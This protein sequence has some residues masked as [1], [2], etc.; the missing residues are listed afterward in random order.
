M[1]QRGNSTLGM[2]LMLLLLGGVTLHATRTQLEKDV[3][4]VADEQ[5]HHKDF[6]Q[7]QAALEWGLAQS[8]PPVSGWQCQTLPSHRWQSCLLTMEEGNALLSG[9]E[10]GR[11]LR[12]WQWVSRQSDSLQP[13]AQGR[14]D[15]CPLP[16][17]EQCQP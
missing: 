15:Y 13:Q 4:L 8:W 2:V 6:W 9:Q 12:L 5:Q 10:E 1:N 17:S 11:E 7:A 14:I 3:V 16:K